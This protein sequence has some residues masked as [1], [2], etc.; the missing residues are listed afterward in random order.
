M[1]SPKPFISIGI[2]T[3]E[4]GPS[5]VTTIKSI[6]AQTARPL[7]KEIVIVLDGSSLKPEII[8][9]LP[10][11]LVQVFQQPNQLGQ[12]ARL[13]D[14]FQAASGELLVVTN[15]DVVL[16][17]TAVAELAAAAATHAAD[18]VSGQAL[19]FPS[20]HW[21]GKLL[22][23]GYQLN[24]HLVAL[25]PTPSYL[26][27]NGRLLALKKSFY[28]NVQLPEQLWNND[29]FLYFAAQQQKRRYYHQP[30]AVVRFQSP[31]TLAEHQ[32]QSLKFQLSRSENE[33]YF[34]PLNAA[35][36][37]P[38]G[39][40]ALALLITGLAH[41]LLTPCYVLLLVWTRLL[42]RPTR[43]TSGVWPTDRSTKQLPGGQS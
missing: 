13:N 29:A 31:S 33:A 11:D 12:S 25:Q 8:K 7:I 15:D 37:V 43:P 2:P 16:A 4:A 19:P 40:L 9:Q 34:G 27:C 38:R 18:L 6:L 32:R 36:A 35:Y 3:H 26:S 30:A 5:L 17:P 21:L 24:H 10:T 22:A 20:R 39:R 14:L 23:V 1:P 41:P 28:K 42:P